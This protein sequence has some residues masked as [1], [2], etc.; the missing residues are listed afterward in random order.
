MRLSRPCKYLAYN[1]PMQINRPV[2]LV[3]PFCGGMGAWAGVSS[4]LP[5][6][7]KTT[8]IKG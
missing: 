4:A 5:S 7:T 8:T 3:L 2:S 6:T 1:R